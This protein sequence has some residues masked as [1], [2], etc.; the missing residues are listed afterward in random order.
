MNERDF[1]FNQ[2]ESLFVLPGEEDFNCDHLLGEHD[3]LCI[4]K[5]ELSTLNVQFTSILS[6]R[7][8]GFID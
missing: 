6:K 1:G 8:S 2:L 5:Q 7:Q 4:L 3:H